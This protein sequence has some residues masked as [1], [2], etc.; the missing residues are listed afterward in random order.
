MEATRISMVRVPLVWWLRRM[1][2]TSCDDRCQR[3][4]Q[5]NYDIQQHFCCTPHIVWCTAGRLKPTVF[6]SSGDGVRK[7]TCS[8]EHLRKSCSQ[9]LYP[10]IPTDCELLHGSSELDAI[11]T[12]II[13]K[14]M[15]RTGLNRNACRVLMGK[16]KGN[17]PFGRPRISGRIILK[18]ILSK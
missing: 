18:W 8:G 2:E 4:K 16:P 12:A 5:R 15:T 3:G 10:L 7:C 11:V 1:L 6:P 13:S 17:T 14:R 9:S